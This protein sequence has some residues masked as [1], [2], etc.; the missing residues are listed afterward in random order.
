MSL[1]SPPGRHAARSIALGIDLHHPFAQTAFML[2]MA[3]TDTNRSE[4]KSLL[5]STPAHHEQS[6]RTQVL[7][8]RSCIVLWLNKLA[9]ILYQAP[10]ND[11]EGRSS[12]VELRNGKLVIRQKILSFEKMSETMQGMSLLDTCSFHAWH[13]DFCL[14]GFAQRLY[15]LGR[16]SKRG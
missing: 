6:C 2:A 8:V 16:C 11:K 15:N 12:L 13:H 5:C 9:Q 14:G 3:T 7:Q 10:V 1:K 4:H